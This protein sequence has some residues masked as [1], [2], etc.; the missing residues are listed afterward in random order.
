VPTYLEKSF[1][2]LAWWFAHRELRLIWPSL[3]TDYY[4][5]RQR[6]TKCEVPV[7]IVAN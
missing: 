3:L 1:R 4:H 5:A 2:Q 7:F 6:S